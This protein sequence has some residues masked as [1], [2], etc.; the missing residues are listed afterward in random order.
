MEL[1]VEQVSLFTKLAFQFGPFFFAVFS[2][3][4]CITIKIPILRSVFCIFGICC[5]VVSIYFWNTPPTPPEHNYIFQISASHKQIPSQRFLDESVTLSRI[6]P[7]DQIWTDH[8]P[9]IRGQTHNE[10][11]IIFRAVAI[12]RRPFSDD[13]IFR[14]YITWKPDSV[15]QTDEILFRKTPNNSGKYVLIIEENE[16]SD[17]GPAIIA[18]IHE[19]EDSSYGFL[20]TLFASAFAEEKNNYDLAK[21]DH[22]NS[23]NDQKFM[24]I[25]EILDLEN[26]EEHELIQIEN[27]INK[28]LEEKY[29]NIREKS[30]NQ[31]SN[32]K[33]LDIDIVYYR[34]LVDGEKIVSILSTLPESTHILESKS[35][36][37][38]KTNALWFGKEI[39][40]EFAVNVAH[41]LI[42]DGVSLKKFGYYS[43][44]NSKIQRIEIGSSAK[45]AN[46]PDLT[47]E[48]ISRIAEKF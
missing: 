11:T 37:N 33:K 18:K 2:I 42:N 30:I 16:N 3:I 9:S 6:H 32:S 24:K 34:K 5:A 31:A 4:I 21:N 7:D 22:S 10:K 17:E 13:S 39:P 20:P 47:T 41:R 23:E 25:E 48:D 44:I 36:P 43:N 35:L 29:S 8:S 1:T 45:S 19:Q 46:L 40:I 27:R 15:K 28:I 26:A 38:M 14:L 12:R